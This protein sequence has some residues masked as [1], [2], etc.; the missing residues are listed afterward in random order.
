MKRCVGA[1][2]ALALVL[3]AIRTVRMAAQQ[4]DFLSDKEEEALRDAQDPG[5][6]IEV[7][8][9]LEQA[10]LARI[11]ELQGH[12]DQVN[13]LL[14]EF[15]SLNEE[16]KDWIEDQ[17]DHHGDMRQGLRSLLERGPRE[18]D[19]LRDIQGWPGASTSEF[20]DNLH[21]AIASVTDGLDGSTKA[22]DDQQKM[23]GEL[24]RE[25]KAEARATK[26]RIKEEKKRAKEEKKLRE[27]MR[28]QSKSDSDQN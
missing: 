4:G 23:F 6:R 17:Y 5:K 18:L 7:Y 9:D 1:A 3:A 2:L 24:K 13:S 22:L 25:N 20:A 26:E 11:M 12:P 19:V 10:R 8:L 28:R 16:M 14:N 21:D 15:I 27:R